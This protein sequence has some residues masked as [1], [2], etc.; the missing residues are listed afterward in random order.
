MNN[1]PNLKYS[2]EENEFLIE[3]YPKYGS[4][5][6]AEHLK[7]SNVSVRSRAQKL[8]LHVNNMSGIMLKCYAK[9]NDKYNVNADLFMTPTN[10]SVIYTMGLLWADGHVHIDKNIREIEL[11]SAYPDGD[12][13]YKI[14]S[15][16]GK[17]NYYRYPQAYPKYKKLKDRITIKTNNRPLS[18]FLVGKGYKSKSTASADDILKIIPQSLHHYWFRG[19]FDGDGHIHANGRK[20]QLTMSGPH[21][22]AWDYFVRLLNELG[23]SHSIHLRIN[24][25]GKSSVLQFGGAKNAGKFLS[26]IYNGAEADKIYLRRKYNKWLEILSY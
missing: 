20:I 12:E 16:Y 11:A 15:S 13:F 4:A 26:F 6:C 2:Q 7:R 8:N 24:S 23:V 14:L 18:S 10:P 1:T 21:T 25:R 5:F 3:N 9:P 17:W 19:L 22:Q